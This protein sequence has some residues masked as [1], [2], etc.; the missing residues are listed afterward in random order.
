MKDGRRAVGGKVGDGGGAIRTDGQ[1]RKWGTQFKCSSNASRL[2][3]IQALSLGRQHQN[4]AAG[5]LGDH[6]GRSRQ[7][8]GGDVADIPVGDRHDRHCFADPIGHIQSVDN[9]HGR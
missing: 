9:G 1:G 5:Q 2:D 6:L 8:R 7:H 3:E 4:A